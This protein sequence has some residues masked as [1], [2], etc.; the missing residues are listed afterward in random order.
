MKLAKSLTRRVT[1]ALSVM[2]AIS[3]GLMAVMAYSVMY[4][5]E[6]E[7]ADQLLSIEMQRLV[8]RLDG[9]ELTASANAIDLGRGMRAWVGD[10]ARRNARPDVLRGLPLGGP[11]EIETDRMQVH[12]LVTDSVHGRILLMFD[13]TANEQRVAQ[14]GVILILLWAACAAGG[15]WLARLVGRAVVEPIRAVTERIADWDPETSD[16]RVMIQSGT[17]E[18]GLLLEAFNRMQDRVDRSMARQREFSS[19]LSHEVRTPLAALRTDIEMMALDSDDDALSQNRLERML[20]T[21]DEITA[22]VASTRALSEGPAAPQRQQLP[23]AELVDG[24]FDGLQSR[25]DLARLE[26]INRI[27]PARRVMVDR[28]ALLI[29]LR[30][31]IGNAIEHASPATLTVAFTD[32]ALLVADDGAGIDAQALPFVFDR[33]HRGRYSDE[34]PAHDGSEPRGLGLAIARRIC[35]QQGW[36]IDLASETE[37]ARRGTRF[38]IRFDENST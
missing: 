32:G 29:V 19:N 9:G 35:Q 3:V 33:N 37:G 22:T 11:Y 17:D 2:V 14:F 27:V 8:E 21:V 4:E 10:A 15:L 6:D 13:A 34:S 38:S 28:Y 1:W 31:L 5:Q 20:A 23:L 26:M 25:A 36:L 30:N 24:V 12:A 16:G 7:L 18:P